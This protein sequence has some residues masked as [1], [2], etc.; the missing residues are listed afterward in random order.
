[1]SLVIYI[2]LNVELFINDELDDIVIIG[3]CFLDEMY[4]LNIKKYYFII[5]YV[6]EVLSDWGI[7]IMEYMNKSRLKELKEKLF[8][9]C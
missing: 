9:L 3:S 5:F 2:G 6:Y 1:M 8:V 7:E 4:W